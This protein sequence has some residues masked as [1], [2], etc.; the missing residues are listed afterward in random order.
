MIRTSS[1]LNV[2]AVGNP[3]WGSI[4]Y[5]KVPLTTSYDLNGEVLVPYSHACPC[6]HC[7]TVCS[8]IGEVQLCPKCHQVLVVVEKFFQSVR[9]MVS[10]GLYQIQVNSFTKETK[11]DLSTLPV[12]QR[13]LLTRILMVQVPVKPVSELV[14]L[15]HHYP[16]TYYVLMKS[17]VKRQPSLLEEFKKPS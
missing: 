15:Y 13:R 11:D 12:R 16:S 7:G 6:P 3:F 9:G 10:M 2:Y 17:M 8:V 14:R 4:Y 5:S 1:G